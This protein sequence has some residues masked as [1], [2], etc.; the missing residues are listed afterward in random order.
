MCCA[1]AVFGEWIKRAV[2][3]CVA[4]DGPSLIYRHT[5]LGSKPCWREWDGGGKGRSRRRSC[6]QTRFYD[7]LRDAVNRAAITPFT[8]RRRRHVPKISYRVLYV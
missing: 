5:E 6:R 3:Q 2:E 1:V 8:D 7:H 4:A